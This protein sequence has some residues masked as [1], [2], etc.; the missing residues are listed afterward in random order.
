MNH[1]TIPHTLRELYVNFPSF[2]LLRECLGGLFTTCLNKIFKNL[3]LHIQPARDNPP[4]LFDYCKRIIWQ[5]LTSST[6]YDSMIEGFSF[7]RNEYDIYLLTVESSA[8]A[9]FTSYVY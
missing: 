5:C 3:D 9:Y 8:M 2:E 6:V 7:P 1:I 4:L